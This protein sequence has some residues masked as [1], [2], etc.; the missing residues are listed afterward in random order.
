MALSEKDSNINVPNVITNS[1]MQNGKLA[2][3]YKPSGSMLMENKL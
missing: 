3:Q 2:G 1:L